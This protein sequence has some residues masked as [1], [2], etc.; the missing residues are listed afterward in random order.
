MNLIDLL[1][2]YLIVIRCLNANKERSSKMEQALTNQ[3]NQV[4]LTWITLI[5]W[6]FTVY[7]LLNSLKMSQWQQREELKNG[8][9]T[10]LLN[11]PGDFN[12]NHI[13]LLAVYLIVIRCLNDNTQKME[14]SLRC[15]TYQI[16]LKII[17]S[18]GWVIRCRYDNEQKSSNME[19]VLTNQIW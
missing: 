16:T 2:V 19:Q 10:H 7:W 1:G 13:D 5:Y 4:T 11:I 9:V 6:V 17:T 8:A 15:Q 18:I 14:H 3:T 12:I